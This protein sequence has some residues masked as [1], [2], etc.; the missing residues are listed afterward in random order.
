MPILTNQASTS[1]ESGSQSYTGLSNI[2][3]FNL[4][5]ASLTAVKSQNVSGGIVGDTVTFTIVLTNTDPLI[6][7]T[8]VIC[9]D[10]LLSHGYTY[11]AGTAKINGTPTTD[12]P[13]TGITVGTINALG[14]KT[15]TFDA[16]VN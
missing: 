12:S 7:V 3:N 11:V 1:Y 13:Q 15:I 2:T 4:F 16:T 8:N 10:D 14:V 9:T 5:N 6:P